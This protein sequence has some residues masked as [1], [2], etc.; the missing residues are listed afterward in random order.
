VSVDKDKE[1]LKTSFHTLQ[2]RNMHNTLFSSWDL[3]QI[4]C[5]TQT[6][7]TPSQ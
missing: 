2:L 4:A 5:A 1:A 7:R 3:L 6:D